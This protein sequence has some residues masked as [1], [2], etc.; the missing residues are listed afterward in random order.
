MS[1][2]KECLRSA[3]WH[4]FHFMH[5]GNQDWKACPAQAEDGRLLRGMMYYIMEHT[6]SY[7]WDPAS[8][9]THS[10]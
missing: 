1:G 7:V 10:T 2:P 6:I 3:E 8:V 9:V 5:A 4:K